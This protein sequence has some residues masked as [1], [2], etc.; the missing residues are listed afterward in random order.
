M[1]EELL[2]A[3]D[4]AAANLSRRK[5]QLGVFHFALGYTVQ[6]LKMR[7]T[8]NDGSRQAPI[9]AALADVDA[10]DV[11]CSSNHNALFNT[12]P[13]ACACPYYAPT[14]DDTI[15]VTP[16]VPRKGLPDMFTR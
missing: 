15:S 12:Q 2:D 14:S 13:R 9:K 3:F 1:K 10:L 8:C 6:L 16:A 7:E 11:A 4:A 5:Q